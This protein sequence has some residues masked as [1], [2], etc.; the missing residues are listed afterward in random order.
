MPPRRDISETDH[1]SDPPTTPAPAPNPQPPPEKPQDLPA[2]EG[3]DPER[4]ERADTLRLADLPDTTDPVRDLKTVLGWLASGRDAAPDGVP[5]PRFKEEEDAIILLGEQME[6]GD[7]FMGLGGSAYVQAVHGVKAGAPPRGEPEKERELAL[8]LR[9][10]VCSGA[11]KSVR[12]CEAGG[13]AVALAECCAGAQEGQGS[14]GGLGAQVDLTQ[15]AGPAPG[16]PEATSGPATEA[17]APAL[18]AEGAQAPAAP[19]ASGGPSALAARL[20]ALLFG[21]GRGRLVISVGA[22]DRGKVLAQAK[23]LE[24]P[25]AWIGVVGGT[26]LEIKTARGGLRCETRE[27][28]ELLRP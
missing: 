8:V 24:A 28:R 4:P 14:P 16:P 7:P 9:A 25:A 3:R 5:T 11:I 23:I 17:S 15:L 19:V 18:P 13:L 26:A 27:L 20:D 21:E 6:A 1:P 10:L 2:G 12:P 22:L